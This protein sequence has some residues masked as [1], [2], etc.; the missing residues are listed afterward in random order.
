MFLALKD[1]ASLF[2]D[3]RGVQDDIL[4]RTVSDRAA[5]EQ[6]MGLFVASNKESGE[7]LEA[8]SNG[9]VAAI[10]DKED[11]L[12][13]YIPTQFPIFFTNDS[14]EAMKEIINLYIEKLDGETN[15]LM[16]R[17]NFKITNKTLLNKN[18]Q[19]YDIAGLIAKLAPKNIEERR[20]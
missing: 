10:W 14:A 5:A 8:I 16:E 6:P 4:F 19:T 11:A 9:A 17:T 18:K 2:Q 20:G 7:L 15:K 13:R 12:P 1:L 3:K